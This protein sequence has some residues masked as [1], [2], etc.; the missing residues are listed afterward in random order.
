[1]CNRLIFYYSIQFLS[2][3]CTSFMFVVGSC[4]FDAPENLKCVRQQGLIDIKH[5]KFLILIIIQRETIY[6]SKTY[7]P[8]V[9][10]RDVKPFSPHYL[11]LKVLNERISKQAHISFY[12]KRFSRYLLLKF[13]REVIFLERFPPY[14]I[15]ESGDKISNF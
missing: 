7:L 9:T 4:N 1:M 2:F 13:E 6:S 11:Y 3:I 14:E 8:Y 12:H 5:H 15:P 10:S